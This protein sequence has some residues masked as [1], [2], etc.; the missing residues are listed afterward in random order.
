M[1]NGEKL[2]YIYGRM[3]AD[4]YLNVGMKAALKEAENGDFTVDKFEVGKDHPSD[5]LGNYCGWGGF[6]EI[7]E[8]EYNQFVKFQTPL[9]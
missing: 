4:T 5:L 8:D 7:T 6:A 2:Y 3:V 1:K 9:P